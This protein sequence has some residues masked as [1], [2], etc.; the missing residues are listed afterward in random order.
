MTTEAIPTV[1]TPRHSTNLGEAVHSHGSGNSS[2]HTVHLNKDN[3]DKA[4]D[5]LVAKD[6]TMEETGL[7]PSL[8]VNCMERWVIW[9]KCAI[10]VSMKIFLG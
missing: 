3:N 6:I 10:I 2:S 8:S 9:F 5:G 7:I 1:D 4:D